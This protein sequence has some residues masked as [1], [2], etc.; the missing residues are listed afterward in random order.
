MNQVAALLYAI[1]FAAYKHSDRRRKDQAESPYINHPIAF[2]HLLA[3]TGGV[4]DVVVLQA[5]IVHD[6]V[7]DA[8]TTREELVQLFCEKVASVVMEVTDDKSVPKA[9]RKELQVE[10]A[11]HMS[12]EAALVRLADKTCNF[13]DVA[14]APPT[15]WSL[16]RRRE[17]FDWGKRV[18]DE[19][20]LVS[21]E[22]RAAFDAAYAK[23]P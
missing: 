23:R 1:S 19:L 3:T 8:E 2:A 14:S 12:R 15:D 7:E 9:R 21:N 4:D 5:A 6:T 20:P 16:K 10:H 13:R 11:P 17:F 18:V 22:L